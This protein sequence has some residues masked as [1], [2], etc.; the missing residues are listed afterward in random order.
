MP[1]WLFILLLLAVALF[2]GCEEPPLEYFEVKRIDEEA[3]ADEIEAFL[4]IAENLPEG[5][6]T[7]M[8]SVF[9]PI[10]DWN[11]ERTLPVREL[12]QE[13]QKTY[14]ERWST[15]WL[16]EHA[17]TSKRLERELRRFR[18]TREQFYG[19]YLLFGTT[20]CSMTI[21]DPRTLTAT[22][23][24]GKE[25][26]AKLNAEGRVYAS[27]TEEDAYEILQQA[28]W[29]T[30]VER[31][32][33]MRLVTPTNRLLVTKHAERLRKVLPAEFHTNPV[34]EF[35]N[36]MDQNGIPFDEEG[37]AGRDSDLTWSPENALIGT[38]A[39]GVTPRAIRKKE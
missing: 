2:A 38:D 29:V 19:L 27:L 26:V 28:K 6:F 39:A 23:D 10:P 21:D 5:K 25:I 14:A 34:I 3:T 33:P 11:R 18:M 1:R 8:P 32:K 24:R 22:L 15:T 13:E 9:P 35:A 12:I 7:K 37:A 30:L 31:L 16:A 36:L 17:P 20:L 4:Q